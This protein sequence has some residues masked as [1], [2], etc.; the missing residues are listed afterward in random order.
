M[1]LGCIAVAAALLAF[2]VSAPKVAWGDPSPAPSS[3][4]IDLA[5][6][7]AG[8]VTV[9]V[10]KDAAVVVKT[11]QSL[12]SYSAHTG[13][14]IRY[15]V[16]Q[17]VIVGG[18]L[19]VKAGDIAEGSVQEGEQGNSGGFYGIGW[20]AANLRISVDR[21]FTFCGSTLQLTFDRSEYRR[22]QGVL[23]SHKDV[24]II[25]GQK[26]VAATDHP[27]EACAVKTNDQPKPIPEDALKPD[28][29]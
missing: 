4:V 3:E 20:K 6:P 11:L 10:P 19:I 8:K 29:G 13:E 25:K 9:K 18:Y 12:N 23:G 7:I 2:V 28:K 27:Q 5:T 21:A 22:R 16:L 26:Y 17:D 24:E 1:R 15:E 14:R